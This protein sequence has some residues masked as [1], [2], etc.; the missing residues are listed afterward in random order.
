MSPNP[1][2]LEV[3]FLPQTEIYDILD[4]LGAFDG[5][6]QSLVYLAKLSSFVNIGISHSTSCESNLSPFGWPLFKLLVLRARDGHP[7]F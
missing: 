5:Y 3:G 1:Y 7:K 2:I 6:G 4:I